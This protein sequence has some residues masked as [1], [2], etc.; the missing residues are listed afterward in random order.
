MEYFYSAVTINVGRDDSRTY[1]MLHKADG[2]G[3][4][5]RQVL[6]EMELE[7]LE[8]KVKIEVLRISSVLAQRTVHSLIGL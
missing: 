8:V 1:R 5:I 2:T 4:V 7:G 3:N 6:A